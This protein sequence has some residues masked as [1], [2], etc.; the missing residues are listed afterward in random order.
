M[1]HAVAGPR[2]AIRP[3]ERRPSRMQ[4]AQR[5]RVSLGGDVDEGGGGGFQGSPERPG[6]EPS[7]GTT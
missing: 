7:P 4:A 5:S 6:V 3:S 1:I 2:R